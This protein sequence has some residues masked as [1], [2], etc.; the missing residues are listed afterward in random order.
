MWRCP[1]RA[2]SCNRRFINEGRGIRGHRKGRSKGSEVGNRV[3]GSE[4]VKWTS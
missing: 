4:K 2:V 1:L 3:C